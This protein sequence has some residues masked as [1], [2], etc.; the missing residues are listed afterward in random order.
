MASTGTFKSLGIVFRQ[1]KYGDTSIIVEIY[2]RDKGLRSF[3]VNGARKAKSPL[4]AALFQHTNLVDIV[5]YDV[6]DSEKVSRIK[7][8]RLAQHYERIQSDMIRASVG[9]FMLEI[10]RNTIIE[11]T[12]NEELFDFLWGQFLYLDQPAT[13]MKLLPQKYLLSLAS[14][15]GCQ[16]VNNFSDTYP[17]F[18]VEEAQFCSEQTICTYPIS[19]YHSQWIARLLEYDHPELAPFGIDREDRD[20]LLQIL[21][22]YYQFHLGVGR[23]IKSYEVLKN[24]M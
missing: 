6:G 15:L 19:R 23:V 2:T 7:E 13:M 21:I 1:I 17:I 3:I 10:A 12:A 18:D 8:V 16:P 9:I 24:I 20:A 14:L 5:A 22:K 4:S 11:R